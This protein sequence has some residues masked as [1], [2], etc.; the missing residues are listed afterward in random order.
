[1]AP[2]NQPAYFYE[3]YQHAAENSLE[4]VGDADWIESRDQ[5]FPEPIQKQLAAVESSGFVVKSQYLDFLKSRYFRRSILCHEGSQFDRSIKPSTLDALYI[6]GTLTRSPDDTQRFQ[7]GDGETLT[8]SHP[9]MSAALTILI[10]REGRP[11]VVRD[12]IDE[13][14]KRSGTQ[15]DD[16]LL[17]TEML[18]YLCGSHFVSL[19]TH[20]PAIAEEPGERPLASPLA[21]FQAGRGTVVTSLL[22][23]SVDLKKTLPWWILTLLD[24]TRDREALKRDL[25]ARFREQGATPTRDGHAFGGTE[26][27]VGLLDRELDGALDAL[28]RQCLL[29]PAAS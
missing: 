28:R 7:N 5:A 2:I 1:M 11:V 10:E 20:C 17:L 6:S 15:N 3:F 14:C 18:F 23:V 4:Y 16:P 29:L 13:A 9:V 24:G 22:H 25:A 12:L 8:I 27:L 19:R 21:R 26:D